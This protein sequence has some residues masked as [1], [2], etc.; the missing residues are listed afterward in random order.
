M[1][2]K[3]HQ[4]PDPLRRL[5]IKVVLQNTAQIAAA[6]KI[7]A[8]L[9]EKIST[10]PLSFTNAE[11]LDTQNGM[12]NRRNVCQRSNV[13]LFSLDAVVLM[14]KAKPMIRLNP[15]EVSQSRGFASK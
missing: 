11:K 9:G 15:N 6:A 4:P 12:R 7:S 8:S 3:K 14:N 1:T 5:R 13:T 10:K 2:V